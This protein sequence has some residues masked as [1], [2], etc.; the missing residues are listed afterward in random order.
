[1][2]NCITI[3]LLQPLI[4]YT[5]SFEC[6]MV[7]VRLDEDA[8]VSDIVALLQTHSH[9]MRILGQIAYKWKH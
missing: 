7:A 3:C 4:T 6:P 5:V 9:F 2:L 8:E 1:M